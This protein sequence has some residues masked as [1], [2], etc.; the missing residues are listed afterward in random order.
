MIKPVKVFNAMN[1]DLVKSALTGVIGTS[2]MSLFSIITSENKNKQ[3]KEHEILS[4]LLKSFP[5]NK[6]NRVA[7]G[8]I[9]HYA[10][11]MSFSILN[12]KILKKLETSPT[13]FNGVLLGAVNGTIGIAIWKAI[14]EIHPSPP[15]IN[16]KRYLAHL[17]IA[18]IV[19]A[20]LSNVTM[21]GV[22]KKPTPQLST[23]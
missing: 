13:F 19:F 2:V 12:Q 10:T 15:N 16:L 11:G 20:A 17:M 22:S 5:L 8:W 21:K 6:S 1:N 23:I 4:M 18:H 7:L 14:F 3:F 9:L